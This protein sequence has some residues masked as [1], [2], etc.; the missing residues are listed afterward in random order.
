MLLSSH[1]LSEVEA[2]CDRV[3]IIRSGAVVETGTLSGLRHLTRTTIA[4]ELDTIP[5]ALRSALGVHDLAVEGSRVHFDVDTAE[6]DAAMRI[7]VAGRIRSLS[8]TPPTLEELFLR[9][10][11]SADEQHDGKQPGRHKARIGAQETAAAR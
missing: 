9:H 1:I 10:Y 11:G 2:L 7:L 6:T 4:A 3:S 5:D 8:A